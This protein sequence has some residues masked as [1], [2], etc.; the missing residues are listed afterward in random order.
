[1]DI[2]NLLH[3]INS[4]IGLQK[5]ARASDE[6]LS[7]DNHLIFSELNN[8]T[9]IPDLRCLCSEKFMRVNKIESD[10]HFSSIWDNFHRVG[11]SSLF[12]RLFI[13]LL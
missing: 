9:A 6:T 13:D 3:A 5:G 11:F 1:M 2:I 4:P 7:T 8:Q 10:F 12:R